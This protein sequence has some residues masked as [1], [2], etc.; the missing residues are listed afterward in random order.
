MGALHTQSYQ[1]SH[2]QSRKVRE[3]KLAEA[4]AVARQSLV[5]LLAENELLQQEVAIL[6]RRVD[7]GRDAQIMLLNQV[8]AL[9]EG[10][11][12]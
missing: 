12:P 11:T 6:E 5:K 8:I 10:H 1:M 7:Y 4:L 3:N 9:K 2:R